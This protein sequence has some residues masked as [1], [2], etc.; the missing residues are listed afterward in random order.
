MEEN[1]LAMQSLSSLFVEAWDAH[2]K[3]GTSQDKEDYE[4]EVVANWK[5]VAAR[6]STDALFSS[7][8]IFDDVQTESIR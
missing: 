4:R 7:N 1:Q 6:V 8:E 2:Q 3:L 5:A